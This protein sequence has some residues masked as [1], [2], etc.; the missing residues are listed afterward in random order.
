MVRWMNLGAMRNDSALFKHWATEVGIRS[1]DFSHDHHGLYFGFPDTGIPASSDAKIK[2]FWGKPTVHTVK[3]YPGPPVYETQNNEPIWDA[4]NEIMIACRRIS[5]MTEH[6]FK[7]I[8][9]VK[10]AKFVFQNALFGILDG[11]NEFTLMATIEKAKWIILA[12]C[13]VA[14]LLLIGE[15][16]FVFRPS[17]KAV[18]L[19]MRGVSDILIGMPRALVKQVAKHY[20]K[21][22][23]RERENEGG[24]DS[25][26]SQSRSGSSDEERGSGSNSS[27]GDRE[28]RSEAGEEEEEGRRR[29]GGGSSKRRVTRGKNARSDRD[30]DEDAET[31]KAE[32][33]AG[34]EEG[35]EDAKKK[36]RKHRR[37]SIAKDEK[38]KGKDRK[39]GG[40]GRGRSDSEDATATATEAEPEKASEFELEISLISGSA[41][42]CV[43]RRQVPVKAEPALDPVA[44][45]RP[46]SALSAGSAGAAAAADAA[47]SKKSSSLQLVPVRSS[48][49]T[50]A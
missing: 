29:H 30:D 37:A 22:Q 10:E 36:K 50:E 48:S 33:S 40:K 7:D 24:S 44:E 49:A 43:R 21:A 5:L 15:A 47:N 8:H 20:S 42:K 1:K 2:E 31:E 46:R 17:F 14:Q 26:D 16:L 35:E 13:L 12:V 9:I 6:Q 25:E 32:T 38:R 41:E 34:E 3:H 28:K 27:D 11:F 18:R 23:K 45:E 4:G 39:R 19:T